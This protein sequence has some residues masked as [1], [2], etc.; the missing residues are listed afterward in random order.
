M[1]DMTEGEFESKYNPIILI[2]KNE[3]GVSFSSALENLYQ[4]YLSSGSVEEFHA[5]MKAW[6]P[7]YNGPLLSI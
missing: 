1:K 2:L 4:E 3:E 7:G 5:E 6:F